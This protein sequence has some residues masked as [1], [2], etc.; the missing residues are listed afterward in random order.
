MLQRQTGGNLTEIV[1]NLSTTI[2]RR[3]ELR[4]KTR[5]MSSEGRTS[6]WVLS[7]LP[8]GIGGILYLINPGY[9]S[10]L[11]DDPLAITSSALRASV[12]LIGTARC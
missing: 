10:I 2:R 6:A 1:S 8:V 3:N 9:M 11:L 4:L 5:A 7:V 12:L